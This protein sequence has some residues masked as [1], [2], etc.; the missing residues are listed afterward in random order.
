WFLWR[1]HQFRITG[2]HV[3]VRKG[4]VFRSHRR[5]PLDRVQGVNLTRPFP[6]RIIGLAKLEVVGAGNDANVDL[7]YLATSRAESVRSDILRLAS[8]A[9][10]ARQ[11]ALDPQ[12]SDAPV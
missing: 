3:E 1:F 11:A 6:A 4:I 8:G 10:A 7:E 5:A 9:R 12:Q 2:D